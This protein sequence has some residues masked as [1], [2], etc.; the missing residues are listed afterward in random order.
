M[1][2]G[3][4]KFDGANV[5][6][7]KLPRFENFRKKTEINKWFIHVLLFTQK[8]LGVREFAQVDALRFT[9]IKTT[10]SK[11]TLCPMSKDLY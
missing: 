5:N 2:I 10:L 11:T 6:L 1:A 4:G 7:S 3:I 8:I 9:T